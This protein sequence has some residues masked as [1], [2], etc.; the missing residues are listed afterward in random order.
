MPQANNKEAKVVFLQR[1][2]DASRSRRPRQDLMGWMDGPIQYVL[3]TQRQL[4]GQT[5]ATHPHGE[6]SSAANATACLAA[7]FTANLY[8]STASKWKEEFEKI[9]SMP[10]SI[11][12]CIL[13]HT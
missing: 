4:Q 8:Q 10:R 5:L 2:R 13:D 7:G 9:S 1:S 6:R 12:I 3:N 11:M